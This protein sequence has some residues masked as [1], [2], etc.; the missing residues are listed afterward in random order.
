MLVPSRGL[1]PQNNK[2]L[3]D[4]FPMK[5]EPF[6]WCKIELLVRRLLGILYIIVGIVLSQQR[7]VK[8]HRKRRTNPLLYRAN[9]A[10]QL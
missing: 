2:P 3:L 1:A 4:L 5:L 7:N 6:L 8:S 10:I 9:S